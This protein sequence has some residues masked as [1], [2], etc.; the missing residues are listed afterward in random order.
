MFFILSKTV[1]I[2]LNP[3]VILMVLLLLSLFPKK[4]WL[5]RTA[6]GLFVFFFLLFTNMVI[7]N[8]VLRWWETP[9]LS[10]SQLPNGN[11]MAIVLSGVTAANKS[12]YDRVHLHKGADR[13]M[14]AVQ[15]YKLGK[16]NRLLLSGGSGLLETDSISEAERMKR[17]MVLSGVPASAIILE[18]ESRNTYENA[19]F[20]KQLLEEQKQEGPYL[21]VTSAF[22][23]PRAIGCFNKAGLQ[24]VPFATDFYSFDP[25]YTLDHYLVP[26]PEAMHAWHKLMK[27]WLGLLTYKVMGYVS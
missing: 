9:G 1:G 10:F 5:N 25:P 22:H 24:V 16:V 6:I 21:L 11:R 15:L 26:S 13:I 2:L 7:T 14:H 20:S 19:Q 23:L 12:P 4:Q 17:V 8:E 27:E 3:L 18:G